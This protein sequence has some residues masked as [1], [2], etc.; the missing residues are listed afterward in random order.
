MT[1][2]KVKKGTE[3]LHRLN[4]LK[5]D[6]KVWEKCVIL[7][8]IA[9]ADKYEYIDTNNIYYVRCNYVN[10]NKL[11]EDTLANIDRMIKEIQEEFDRL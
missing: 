4:N 2:E 10:F 5:E 7:H 3:L 11:K 6:R 8:N 9:L 1:E